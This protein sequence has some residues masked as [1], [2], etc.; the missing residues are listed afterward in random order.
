MHRLQNQGFKDQKVQGAL[1]KIYLVSHK[2]AP[3]ECRQ[4]NRRE[5]LSDVNSKN[6]HALPVIWQSV[7]FDKPGNSKLARF[8]QDLVQFMHAPRAEQVKMTKIWCRND[9]IPFWIN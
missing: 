2:K 5:L 4:Q 7:C 6:P 1:Q 8:A 9:A 3:L